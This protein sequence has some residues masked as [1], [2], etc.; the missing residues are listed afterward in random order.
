MF[1]APV[2]SAG[3]HGARKVVVVGDPRAEWT[4]P[5][6]V[7]AVIPRNAG[8]VQKSARWYGHAQIRYRPA[9]RAHV[10]ARMAVCAYSPSRA[11]RLLPVVNA[12]GS[13]SSRGSRGGL[14]RGC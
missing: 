2:A 6:V 14:G 12:W 1:S 9:A 3:V 5:A 13:M 7:E 10:G 4:V 8:G 11:N